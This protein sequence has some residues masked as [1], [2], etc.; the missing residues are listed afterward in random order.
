MRVT[1]ESRCHSP[2]SASHLSSTGR[3]KPPQL[4][5]ICRSSTRAPWCLGCA[6]TA[7]SRSSLSSRC[8]S[9][10]CCRLWLHYLWCSLTK[11]PLQSCE[12]SS[13]LIQAEL[14]RARFTTDTFH[15]V[16]LV[17][18]NNAAREFHGTGACCTS[19]GWIQHIAV[20]S[21]DELCMAGE[22]VRKIVRARARL[23]A[24]S[25]RILYVPRLATPKLRDSCL[26]QAFRLQASMVHTAA[27]AP[28]LP[29][30]LPHTQLPTSHSHC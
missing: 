4:L 27:V 25:C 1:S 22:G 19:D 26:R 18:H 24:K 6:T 2:C 3:K 11:T 12:D 5:R 21:E 15:V 28:G 9:R 23:A 7:A 14:H 17:N 20:W 10:A 30:R 16:S 13:H 29:A 8:G